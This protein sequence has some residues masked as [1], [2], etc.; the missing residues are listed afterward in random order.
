MCARAYDPD[1]RPVTVRW[2]QYRDA[3]TYPGAVKITGATRP[4][5][6]VTVPADAQHGQTIHLV[7][8]VEDTAAIPLT[9]YTRT[10]LTVR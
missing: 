8:T 1:A 9:H 5:T 10:V 3:G 6:R 2:W 4:C 7:L